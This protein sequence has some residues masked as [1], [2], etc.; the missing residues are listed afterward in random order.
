MLIILQV[1][2]PVVVQQSVSWVTVVLALVGGLPATVAAIGGIMALLQ[3]RQNAIVA[4]GTDRKVDEVKK[5]GATIIEKATEIHTLTNSNLA[6]VTHELEAANVKIAGFAQ[7][8]GEN[9]KKIERLETMLEK[10]AANV[11]PAPRGASDD[12]PLPVHDAEAG[13]KLDQI[14]NQQAKE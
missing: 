6:R 12:P 7:A 1:A 4:A 3:S 5:D 11:V 14:I 2:E 13:E 8:Q 9:N 10:L